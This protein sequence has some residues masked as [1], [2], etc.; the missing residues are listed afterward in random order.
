MA[1][2]FT[3]H[4]WGYLNILVLKGGQQYFKFGVTVLIAAI[5]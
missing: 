5:L 1:L 3:A 4:K 2:T